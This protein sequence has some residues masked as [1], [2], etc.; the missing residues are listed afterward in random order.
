MLGDRKL[1]SQNKTIIMIIMII[2]I[3]NSPTTF[4]RICQV[5]Y[6]R[7]CLLMGEGETVLNF[8]LGGSSNAGRLAAADRVF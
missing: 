8:L 1:V 7:F 5:S 4:C 6:G 2:M 3:I